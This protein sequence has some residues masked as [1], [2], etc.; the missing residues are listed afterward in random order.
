MCN[1]IYR[2]KHNLIL[3]NDELIQLHNTV[4]NTTS[5]QLLH[6]SDLQHTDTTGRK[7]NQNA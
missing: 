2:L 6:V 1:K 7:V 5:Q 4:S 3:T